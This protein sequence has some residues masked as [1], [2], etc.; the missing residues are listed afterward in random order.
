[1]ATHKTVIARFWLWLF[2]MCRVASRANCRSTSTI[3][4][5]S[6]CAHYMAVTVL[7]LDVTV[8]YLGV[9]VLYLAVTV[10]YM[11]RGLSRE[12]QEHVHHRRR[13]I[14]RRETIK[15]FVWV[16]PG[17]HKTVT[18]R[19]WPHIRQAQP[20]Y[21]QNLAVTVSYLASGA[22]CRSTFSIVAASSCAGE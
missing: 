13:L 18:D 16:L 14:L 6:S 10:S 9:T 17:I 3:E 1:M 22:N 15:T 19:L 7:S 2:Y 20:D 21:G 12:V 5:A 4:V 8:L 11:P